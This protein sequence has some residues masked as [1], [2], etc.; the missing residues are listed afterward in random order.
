MTD[1]QRLRVG[2]Y[3]RPLSVK[4]SKPSGEVFAEKIVRAW[5]LSF[6]TIGFQLRLYFTTTEKRYLFLMAPA[7]CLACAE[8]IIEER[9]A[10]SG[11]GASKNGALSARYND[12]LEGNDDGM[13]DAGGWELKVA[14]NSFRE[15]GKLW[16]LFQGDQAAVR[17]R[18]IQE[19]LLGLQQRFEI[20]EDIDVEMPDL[21]EAKPGPPLYGMPIAY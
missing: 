18:R 11:A 2:Y 15:E 14:I 16:W 9:N 6:L 10:A 1:C 20:E 21:F 12:M 8:E 17:A 5:N 4:V 3:I 19:A 13:L 7:E